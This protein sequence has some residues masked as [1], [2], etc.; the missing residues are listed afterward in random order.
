LQIIG[1]G[2]TTQVNNA[3][4]GA[5]KGVDDETSGL[6]LMPL[7]A[8]LRHYWRRATPSGSVRR[9]GADQKKVEAEALREATTPDARELGRTPEMGEKWGPIGPAFG[10]GGRKT[11]AG[12]VRQWY[13]RRHSKA[14]GNAETR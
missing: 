14:D 12:I 10:L 2:P 8:R 5:T 9:A 6:L 3:T 7:C 13:A 1:T 4:M 11:A